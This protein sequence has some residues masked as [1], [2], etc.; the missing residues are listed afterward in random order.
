MKY[1]AWTWTKRCGDCDAPIG[2]HFRD[3]CPASGY[4]RHYTMRN[5]NVK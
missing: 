4:Y 5:P 2:K 3:D 1:N